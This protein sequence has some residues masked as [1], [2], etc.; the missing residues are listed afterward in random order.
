M[1]IYLPIAGIPINLFTLLA[2]GL[3][4]GFLSGMFG[5]GGGFLLTPIL[6]FIGIPPAIAVG[7]GANQLVATSLSGLIAHFRRGNVDFKMGGVMLIGGAGGSWLGIWIFGI[8]REIGQID[9]VISLSFVTF[10]LVVGSL[11]GAESVRAILRRRRGPVRRK[12][13]SHGW[14]HGLPLKMRFRK[15]KLYVSAL[16]PVTIGFITGLF[17][18]V[19]GVGGGFL[20]IPAMIYILGMTTSVVIGTSLLQIIFVAGIATFLH[21]LNNQT[22][23]IL[24]VLLLSIGAVLGAELGV[25]AGLKLRAEYLRALLALVVLVVVVRLAFLLVTPPANEFS[26]GIVELLR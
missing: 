24:L 17:A 22:V 5:V 9:L 1:D 19:M 7:S 26:I 21:A 25:R 3:A 12:A 13:H 4:V 15:S 2:L 10:L 18:A 6:I 8:L 20:M 16:L 11:M 23:D 14:I